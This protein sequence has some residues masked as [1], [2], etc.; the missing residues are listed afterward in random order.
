MCKE[1]RK[2]KNMTNEPVALNA[3]LKYYYHNPHL[4]T[5]DVTKKLK[6]EKD[7]S[8]LGWKAM[9]LSPNHVTFYQKKFELN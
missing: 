9:G 2:F 4:L 1:A 8:K 5:S 3:K 6:T 7:T